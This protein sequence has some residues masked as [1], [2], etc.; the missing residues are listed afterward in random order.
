MNT[1]GAIIPVVPVASLRLAKINFKDMYTIKNKYVHVIHR[2]SL[3]LSKTWGLQSCW[4]LKVKIVHR[5]P[6]LLTFSKHFKVY[7]EACLVVRHCSTR[8]IFVSFCEWH[9]CQCKLLGYDFV[10]LSGSVIESFPDEAKIYHKIQDILPICL[11]ISSYCESY[12]QV[13]T[14][15]DWRQM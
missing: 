5:M 9:L 7:R 12:L 6:L 1:F 10:L 2:M 15:K 8:N 14:T 11:K 13:R 3:T 4:S